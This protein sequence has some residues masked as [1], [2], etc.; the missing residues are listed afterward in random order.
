MSNERNGTDGQCIFVG[1]PTYSGN[2]RKAEQNA[3]LRV[4]RSRI[5]LLQN[6]STRKA[7]H[8]PGTRRSLNGR[9]APCVVEMCV[10]V[11]DQNDIRHR[12][13][14]RLD[15]LQN[16]GAESGR[17]PSIR[18]CPSSAVIRIALSP[19]VPT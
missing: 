4:I 17:P 14:Q 5:A 1:E 11:E 6:R 9:H 3:I 18:M 8:H 2:R 19:C 7:R 10:R 15:A 16:R 13:P 12:K